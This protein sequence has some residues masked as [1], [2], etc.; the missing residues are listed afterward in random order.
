ME[1]R[2]STGRRGGFTLLECLVVVTVLALSLALGAGPLR[3]FRDRNRLS[4]QVARFIS[5]IN[6]AR[7][8]AVMRNTSGPGSLTI[9]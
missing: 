4:A 5:A 1:E 2:I 8:E 6:I 9:G 7:S 3:D